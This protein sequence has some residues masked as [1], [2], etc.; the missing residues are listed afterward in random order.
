MVVRG[1]AEIALR[2]LF[3]DDVV[4]VPGQR[5]RAR[6]RRHAHDVGAQHP[7]R[8]GRGRGHD[9]LGRPAARPR[10][11][12]TSTPSGSSRARSRRV[13]V[14]TIVGTRPEIIRLARVI[15]RLDETVDHVL[16]HTGQNYDHS[17]N[18]VF[19]DDLGLRAPDHYLGVDT[20]SLGAVLGGVLIG[21]ERVLLEERPDAVL[22]LGDTNSCIAARDGQADADPRLP[23]GGRQPVLRRERAGGDEPAA[24]RPR[25]RLQPRLHRARAPQPAGRGPA[26]APS[27]ADGVPDARG[28]RALP[29]SD[30]RLR[31]AR[32]AGP[33][34]AG[35]TSSSARTARR[36]ST[37]P[38]RL[39]MLLECLRRCTSGGTCRSSSRPIRA[40]ASG[41]RRST[42]LASST[43]RR[44]GWS[45]SAST[46]TTSCSWRP[47][48]CSRTAARS[49]RSRAILGFP[50]VTLRDSIERPEALDAGAIMMTGLDAENVVGAVTIAMAGEP[51]FDAGRLRDRGHLAARRAVHGLDEQEKC[52]MARTCTSRGSRDKDRPRRWTRAIAAAPL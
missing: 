31:R 13:K 24:G 18:Q 1:E 12:P 15:Q 40:R 3:H 10:A 4:T 29:H 14:M 33:R 37:H 49:P 46:T 22:V 30:R 16:V 8:R 6:V 52:R 51:V 9:V 50:A 42:A 41:W 34:A 17:L 25:R 45:R 32:A 44:V 11:T 27:H 2:R 43:G 20:S 23:H 7:Q 38:A 5:R 19:F 47:P 39:R 28:A 26:P 36:T 48:A 21:T 35:R